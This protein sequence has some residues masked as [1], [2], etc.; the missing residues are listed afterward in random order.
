M[1]DSDHQ[2][3]AQ[4]VLVIHGGAGVQLG[5]DYARPA[6]FM[7]ELLQQGGKALCS[8]QSALDL[9]VDM[10][11]AMEE[12]GLF[13]AGK[14]SSPNHLGEVELDAS[15]MTGQDQNAGAV[16]AIRNVV[17]PVRAARAVMQNSS[18]VLLAGS[19]AELFAEQ[20]ALAKV[21]DA[22]NYYRAAV[23]VTRISDAEQ[24]SSPFAHGTVGAVALDQNAQ[25]AAATSTGGTLN[26]QAGRV[27]DTPLIGS[28]TWA[29]SQVAVSC[30]G[31]GEFFIRCAAAH[32]VAAR[33]AYKKQTLQQAALASIDC[34]ARLGGDGGLIAVDRL[35]NVAMPFNTRGMKRGVVRLDGK[36]HVDVY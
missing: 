3:C 15:V 30:T 23:D 13:T 14:G 4:A 34:V 19:G 22:Q 27:G 21:S 18:Y 17:N 26:K 8:G 24:S 31:Q 20:Q 6:A 25:L 5:H 2:T 7:N 35:G 32:D 29:D 28:A 10:V 9:V 33:I 36:V 1:N 12:S 16:A 11:A